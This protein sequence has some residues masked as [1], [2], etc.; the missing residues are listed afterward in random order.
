MSAESLLHHVS[1]ETLDDLRRFEALFREEAG[2]VNLVSTA[3]LDQLWDRHVL[4]SLQIPLLKPKAQRWLDLGSGGGFPGLITAILLKGRAGAHI[5]L[6][7]STGKKARVLQSIATALSL[8]A[9]VWNDRIESLSNAI[10]QPDMVSARAL[11]PLPRLLDLASPWLR[12]GATGLFP[13]GR[14]FR[15]EIE[16]SRSL[17]RFDVIEHE[18]RTDSDSAILEISALRRR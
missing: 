11:A 9:T 2:K 6:V 8:P 1:R 17:W 16:E 13:K 3:S 4:D 10:A 12:A 18:S 14:S 15:Q 5:D 7:E